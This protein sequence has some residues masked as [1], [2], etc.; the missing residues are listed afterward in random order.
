TPLGPRTGTIRAVQHKYVA[1]FQSVLSEFNRRFPEAA[2]LWKFKVDDDLANVKSLLDARAERIKMAMAAYEERKLTVGL[3]AQMVQRSGLETWRTLLG[4][5]D[6]RPFVRPGHHE[7]IFE[8][9]ETLKAADAVTLDLTFAITLFGFVLPERVNQ[10]HRQ[11]LV[12]QSVIDAISEEI[13]SHKMMDAGRP[14]VV[15]FKRG[16]TYYREEITPEQTRELVETFERLRDQLRRLAIVG[17]PAAVPS[18]RILR[19]PMRCPPSS[20]MQLP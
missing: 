19:W 13:D 9:I 12:P 4:G 5:S 10:Y 6:F 1:R 8:A 7:S 14:T 16:D 3:L 20:Q 15:T 2:G 17:R 11:V 18:T